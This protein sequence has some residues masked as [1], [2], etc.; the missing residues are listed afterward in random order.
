MLSQGL[1]RVAEAMIVKGNKR[2]GDLF[3]PIPCALACSMEGLTPTGWQ[4]L[5]KKPHQRTASFGRVEPSQL[6]A[7]NAP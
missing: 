6:G 2:E 3:T 4:V 5:L 7:S 1:G